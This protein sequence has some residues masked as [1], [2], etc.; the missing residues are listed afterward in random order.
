MPNWKSITAAFVAAFVVTLAG[1]IFFFGPIEQAD[2]T[3]GPLLP[4]AIGFFIY[5]ALSISLFGWVVRQ[6]GNPYKAAFVIAA[7]QFILVD[8]D[9]VLRGQRGL[10]TAAASTALLAATWFAVA[11]AYSIFARKRES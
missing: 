8:V 2:T 7:A 9:F 6:I 1:V 5:V 4:P 10:M 11:F 3:S